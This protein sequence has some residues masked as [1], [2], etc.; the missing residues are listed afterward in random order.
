M[1]AIVGPVQVGTVSG[2]SIQFGDAF[3][4]S[5]K[6]A[7]K[8]ASGSGGQNTGVFIITNNGLS[9]TNVVDTNLIDQPITGNN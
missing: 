6:S 2:G 5:P 3:F 4:Y 9:A 7:T 1:P 8:S